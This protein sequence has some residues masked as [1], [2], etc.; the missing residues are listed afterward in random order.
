[1]PPGA[2]LGGGGDTR[3]TPGGGE[4]ADIMRRTQWVCTDYPAN[5]TPQNCTMTLETLTV[6]QV[7]HTVL[8]VDQGWQGGDAVVVGCCW[9]SDLDKVHA[10]VVAIVINGLQALQNVISFR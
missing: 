3:V 9:V 7:G 4:W 1:M 10:L 2:A 8:E 6:K 5:I